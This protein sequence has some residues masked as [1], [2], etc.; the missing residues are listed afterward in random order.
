MLAQALDVLY[1]C[2]NV[3]KKCQ[4]SCRKKG[5]GGHSTDS[6]LVSHHLLAADVQRVLF[7]AMG[8]CM[9]FPLCHINT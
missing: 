9:G 4:N 7:G 2:N 8:H 6:M 5:S 1:P 3:L